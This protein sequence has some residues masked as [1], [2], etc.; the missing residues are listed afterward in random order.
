MH[1]GKTDGKTL[2]RTLPAR[3]SASSLEL[4]SARKV[5]WN[6]VPSSDVFQIKTDVGGDSQ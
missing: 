1:N 3:V 4:R 2:T 5:C 6:G